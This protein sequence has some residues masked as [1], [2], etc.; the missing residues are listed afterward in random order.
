MLEREEIERLNLLNKYVACG[1]P[2]YDFMESLFFYYGYVRQITEDYI[3]IETK[4]G[5]RIVKLS[6]IIDIHLTTERRDNF[7]Y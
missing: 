4:K 3:K 2:N 6:K 7:D 1:V 5:F